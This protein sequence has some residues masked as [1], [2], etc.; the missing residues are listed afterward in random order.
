MSKL[1]I[2]D[3]HRKMKKVH[4]VRSGPLPFQTSYDL[5]LL[6]RLTKVSLLLLDCSDLTMKG[7]VLVTVVL[8]EPRDVSSGTKGRRPTSVR[9]R[10]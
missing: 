4:C 3:S 2:R 7:S 5:G 9:S 1:F 10:T 8:P 6:F